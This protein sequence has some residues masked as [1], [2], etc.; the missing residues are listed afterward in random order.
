MVDVVTPAF[1]EEAEID[2]CLD[3]VFGQSY[4]AERMRV[5][6]V[7]AGSTDRTVDIVRARPEPQLSL[8]AGHGRL[9]AGQALNLG[10]GAGSAEL[11]ARVDA[12]THLAPDYLRRAVTLMED[13][14][15]RLALVSGQPTQVGDTRFGEG[16][17][18]ARRSRFGVGGGSIYAD[19]RP[20]AYVDTVQGGVYRRAALDAVGRFGTAY[21]AG[22]DEECNWRLRK[23]GYDV[24]LDT[25]LEF[26][27]TT[28]S[29]WSALFRQHRNYGFSRALVVVSHPDYLR[30]RHLMPSAF[31]TSVAAET[32]AGLAGRRARRALAATL[33]AYGAS[34]GAASAAATRDDPS[35]APHVAA[36]FVAMHVGYGLGLVAGLSSVVGAALG[37]MT[38]R[39]TVVRR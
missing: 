4:P 30:V 23:A 16:V 5:W 7:D 25:G 34:V 17:V 15:P 19:R 24:L 39:V 29:S 27:Y 8:V 37:F 14:G 2:R 31:V 13:L 11:I 33:V 3:C 36:A 20:R 32:V 12:H 18:R 6:V 10:I 22:E 35:L 9:N 26:T 21:R 28:R 38:P 1:N